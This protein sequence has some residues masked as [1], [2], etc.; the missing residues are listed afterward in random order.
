MEAFSP[1][2]CALA[3]TVCIEAKGADAE[4]FLR[5]QLTSNPPPLNAA[6]SVPAAWLDARGR[7]QALFRVLGLEDRW[8]L[9]A[10]S[11]SAEAVVTKLR[12][13]VL[14]SRVELDVNRERSVIAFL[15]RAGGWRTERGL[16]ATFDAGAV[17][18]QGRIAWLAVGPELLLA[19]GPEDALA[20]AAAGVDRV[21]HEQEALAE[22]RLGL[23]RLS[24]VLSER[25]VPQMLNLDLLGAIAFDKGCYPGQEV[26]ARLK[27]RGSV[28]RR[29]RRFACGPLDRPPAPGDEIVG[30]AGSAAGEVVRAA[31]GGGGF[32]LLAVVQLDAEAPLALLGVPHASMEPLPLPYEEARG[33]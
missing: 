4:A 15:G 27:Y 28:K 1:L 12:R 6:R 22:I 24:G 20:S 33:E 10:E 14:R 29:M 30:A 18:L 25:Y 5:A 8:L 21:E 16:A 19:V 17:S 31:H 26:V 3:D 13:F 32:E 23:P 2:A 7:V 9:L 11:A